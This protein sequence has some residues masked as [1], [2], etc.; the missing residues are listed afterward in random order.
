[1]RHADHSTII[2]SRL[3]GLPLLLQFAPR[4]VVV[5]EEQSLVGR[6]VA[7]VVE[8]EVGAGPQRREVR[9]VVVEGVY[10]LRVAAGDDG[11]RVD[12]RQRPL[13]HHVT[14]GPPHVDDA[15]PPPAVQP[16]RRL[17]LA[18]HPPQV[19][20]GRLGVV[21]HVEVGQRLAGEGVRVQKVGMLIEGRQRRVRNV[22]AKDHRGTTGSWDRQ[23]K[24]GNEPTASIRR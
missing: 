11:A 4:R 21:V 9:L 7:D 14:H 18:Q 13:S 10:G 24:R 23:V 16:V 6:Q 1:M 15:P 12:E 22:S 8:G 20:L 2:T 3:G 5:D 19:D 17:G